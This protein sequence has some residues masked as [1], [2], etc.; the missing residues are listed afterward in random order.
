LKYVSWLHKSD[1]E[2]EI[3]DSRI[4]SAVYELE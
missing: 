3:E 2:I 4:P 1:E